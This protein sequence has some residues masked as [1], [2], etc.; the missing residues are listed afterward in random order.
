MAGGA[1]T[2]GRAAICS[3]RML[4]TGAPTA[5]SAAARL[6]A[7]SRLASSAI[8]A[9]R[10]WGWIARQTSMAL[11]APGASSGENGPNTVAVGMRL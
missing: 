9:T 5:S 3:I 1:S 10:S 2:S 4:S 6:A 11:R 8:S 7:T